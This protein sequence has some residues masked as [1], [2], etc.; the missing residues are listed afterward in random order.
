ML[1]NK[2]SKNNKMGFVFFIVGVIV[3]FVLLA[4]VMHS[5]TVEDN[6]RI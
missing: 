1:S 3:V 6:G 2:C 4:S 5:E